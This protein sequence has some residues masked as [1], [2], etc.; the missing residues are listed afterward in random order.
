LSGWSVWQGQ[1]SPAQVQAEPQDL[2]PLTIVE[3]DDQIVVDVSGAVV[4]PGMYQLDKGARIGQAITRAG[5]Y[6][7]GVDDRSV[8]QEIN[9]AKKLQ[10][11]DKIYIPFESDAIITVAKAQ[12]D[13]AASSS[14]SLNSATQ[15]EL[16]TLA[17]I[18]EVRAKDIIAGRPY[19]QLSDLVEQKILSNTVFEQLQDQI[20]L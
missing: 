16:E 1:I 6:R 14:V 11:E 15:A 3:P 19:S 18:G 8:A 12:L 7:L 20:S 5:G 13:G 9:L 10:D 4:Q 2:A 17:G